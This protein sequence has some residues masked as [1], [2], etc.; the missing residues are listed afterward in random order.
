MPNNKIS[1]EQIEIE[2]LTPYVGNSKIH[3]AAQIKHIANSIKEFG[4]NDPLAIAGANNTVLE[5]NGRIQAAKLLGFTVLPCIRLDHLSA[6]EQRA[7]IIA[8]NAL[9]L[10]TGFDESVLLQELQELRQ[11]DFNDFGVETEKYITSLERLQKKELRPYSKVHYLI[12][13]D[14]NNNDKIAGIIKQIS[15]ME[16]VEVDSSLD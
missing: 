9:N 8:H 13:L 14:I 11:F 2:N 3:T 4:F 6:D 1:I 16:G 10:E 5:G 15:K 12:S 7:Y